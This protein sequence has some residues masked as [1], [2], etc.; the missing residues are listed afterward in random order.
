MQLRG[1]GG[2]VIVGEEES[3]QRTNLFTCVRDFIQHDRLENHFMDYC[4]MKQQKP[5]LSDKE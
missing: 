2:Q 5:I 1:K 3:K 4:D